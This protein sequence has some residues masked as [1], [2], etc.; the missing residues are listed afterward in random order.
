MTLDDIKDRCTVDED[1]GCWHWKG[2]LS[3]GKWPRI[4]APNHRKPGSPMEVQTGRRAVWHVKTGVAIPENHRVYGTCTD[5]QCL[6]DAHMRCGPPR[7]WGKHLAKT[8]AYKNKVTR[9][10]ASRRTGRARS[11]LT[12]DLI[13]E[14][15][16]S[17]ESGREI[18]RRTGLSD[19]TVSKA[20]NGKVVSFQPIGGFASGLGARP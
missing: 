4:H 13:A 2:A 10:I 3:E 11:V 7:D 20:R 12:A 8:G 1:T 14:I 19:Q 16:Q 6:N 15:Q 17:T 5:P 18:V 9:Q